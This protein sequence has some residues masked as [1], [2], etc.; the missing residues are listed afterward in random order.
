MN[1]KALAA[2]FADVDTASWLNLQRP[3]MAGHLNQSA[4]FYF[5]G[6]GTGNDKRPPALVVDWES[7]AALDPKA[8]VPIYMA[9][10]DA[11]EL[12]TMLNAYADAWEA[13]WD[14]YERGDDWRSAQPPAPATDDSN[15]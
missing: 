14:A 6:S 13:A 1:R 3:V 2:F 4:V 5:D 12:A 11:R 15:P 9:P 10:L 8:R 7:E